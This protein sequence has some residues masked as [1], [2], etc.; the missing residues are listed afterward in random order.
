[1]FTVAITAAQVNFQSHM[2]TFCKGKGYVLNSGFPLWQKA[3]ANFS[4]Y[5]DSYKAIMPYEQFLKNV[6]NG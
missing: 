4:I 3:W 2:E 1:M 5:S 6:I